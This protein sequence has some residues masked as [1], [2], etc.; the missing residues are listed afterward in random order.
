MEGPKI[1]SE[2]YF[3]YHLVQSDFT[4]SNDLF[5]IIILMDKKIAILV[6]A[7]EHSKFEDCL[8]LSTEV[9]KKMEKP[10]PKKKQ[11][12]SESDLNN[13]YLARIGSLAATGQIHEANH[14]MRKFALKQS[15]DI[16][17]LS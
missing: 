13:L 8:R 2:L 14:L 11:Q 15:K 3:C 5:I 12:L 6:E 7:F 16:R 17:V 10:D 4:H 9:L 1:P